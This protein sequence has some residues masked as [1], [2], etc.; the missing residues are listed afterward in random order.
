[1]KSFKTYFLFL[2]AGINFCKA[3]EITLLI[4]PAMFD[5]TTDQL[6]LGSKDGWYFKE[7]NDIVWAKKDV[8]ITNWKKIKPIELTKNWLIKMGS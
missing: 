3:Q 7:G 1:M 5:K 6:L 4:S 8:D 2:F